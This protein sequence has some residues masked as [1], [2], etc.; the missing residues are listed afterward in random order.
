MLSSSEVSWAAWEQDP[1]LCF[2]FSPPPH[3]SQGWAWARHLISPWLI[4]ESH[5]WEVWGKHKSPAWV[6]GWKIKSVN[7]CFCITVVWRSQNEEQR[8]AQVITKHQG[9]VVVT[10]T[11]PRVGVGV[12]ILKIGGV[13]I[14]NQ[15][16]KHK[17]LRL[18]SLPQLR[19]AVFVP[20]QS[21]S[22]PCTA[23]LQTQPAGAAESLGIRACGCLPVGGLL[24]SAGAETV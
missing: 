22:H 7:A 1:G 6:L 3:P 11:C 13:C 17:S 2:F 8:G 16:Y 4:L 24:S 9:R 15:N 14:S 5:K 20:R 18:L 23:Q 21:R 12:A 19:V 10:W